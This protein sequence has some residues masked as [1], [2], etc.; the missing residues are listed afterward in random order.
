MKTYVLI[1]SN[2]FP[3]THYRSGERTEFPSKVL[4]RNDVGGKKHTLRGNY[5]LWQKRFDK[6]LSGE[7]ILSVR[8]WSGRPYHSR[9]ITITDL[10][11]NDGIGLQRVAFANNYMSVLIVDGNILNVEQVANN[12][13]LSIVDFIGWFKHKRETN[14]DMALIHFTNF[15]Y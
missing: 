15:R 6:I 2:E 4:K 3:S 1:V 14:K 5:A 13:G 10:S 9:Q 11:V 8:Y 7:A 12:D